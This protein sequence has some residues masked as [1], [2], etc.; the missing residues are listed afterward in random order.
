MDKTNINMILYT[1]GSAGTTTKSP[2]GMGYHGYFYEDVIKKTS[3]VPTGAFPSKK[4]YIGQDNI[5]EFA[6][7]DL[8]QLKVSPIGYLD[9]YLAGD[10]FMGTSPEAEVYATRYAIESVVLYFRDSKYHLEKIDIYTDSMY[11]IYIFSKVIEHIKNQELMEDILRDYKNEMTRNFIPKVYDFLSAVYLDYPN[12]KINLFKI[13][14]HTGNVGNELADQLA[15]TARKLYHYGLK[16]V[17]KEVWTLNKYWKP[18]VTRHPFL[19]YKEL[20]FMHNDTDPYANLTVMNYTGPDKVGSR[21]GNPIYGIIRLKEIPSIIKD[22]IDNYR[23]NFRYDPVLVY[24]VDMERLYRP[25]YQS[26]IN[27]FGIQSFIPNKN[28]QLKFLDKEPVIYPVYPA[29]MGRKAY[30]L[31]QNLSNILDQALLDIEKLPD[32]KTRKVIDITDKIYA[33]IN[34]KKSTVLGQKDDIEVEFDSDGKK[35]KINLIQD[36]DIINRNHFKQMEKDDV[37]VYLYLVRTGIACWVYYTVIINKTLDAIGIWH[38]IFSSKV[39]LP[40]EKK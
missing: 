20:F 22:V 25:E 32:S 19:R 13:A 15:G 24:A 14:G 9:G 23:S 21:T 39:I 35:I 38:N 16:R 11:S 26:F 1:D 33:T 37:L 36:I 5:V 3:D 7:Q 40:L 28:S 4:G 34:K 6:A 29:G 10:E 27:G 2:L 17:S 18:S 12:L 30:D 8:E 31:T